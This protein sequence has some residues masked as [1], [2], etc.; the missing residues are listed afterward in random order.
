L[1]NAV[2]SMEGAREAVVA[3]GIDPQRRGETLSV[4]EFA[5]IERALRAEAE[6]PPEGGD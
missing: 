2:R 6:R 1:W 5:S 3:A 4:A